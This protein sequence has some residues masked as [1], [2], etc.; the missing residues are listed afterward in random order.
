MLRNSE[1]KLQEFRAA[2]SAYRN[3][4]VSAAQLIEGFFAL[5]DTNSKEMGKL[6]KELADIF[7]I[8]TKREGLLK[9]WNDGK[10]VLI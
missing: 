7:E 6:I 1:I 5:F 2:V 4:K 3:S 10:E 9:A 8:P